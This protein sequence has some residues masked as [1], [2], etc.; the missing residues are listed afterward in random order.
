MSEKY[1]LY[2]LSNKGSGVIE[3]VLC[4]P[5]ICLFLYGFIY[6]NSYFDKEQRMTVLSRSQGFSHS[7]EQSD[8]IYKNDFDFKQNNNIREDQF[9]DDTIKFDSK[10]HSLKITDTW[11]EYIPSIGQGIGLGVLGVKYVQTQDKTMDVTKMSSVRVGEEYGSAEQTAYKYLGLEDLKPGNLNFE[12]YS[13][14]D[15]GF[16]ND[17][18]YT[19][20]TPLYWIIGARSQWGTSYIDD[21]LMK[22]RPYTACNGVNTLWEVIDGIAAAK[23]SAEVTTFGAVAVVE[24][25]VSYL[26]DEVVDMVLDSAIGKITDYLERKVYEMLSDMEED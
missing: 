3:F 18:Y 11:K 16:L 20:L 22:Y 1:S 26:A 12:V 19:N 15:T 17:K 4:A 13:L 8:K 2:F 25:V 6:I 24:T 23:A 10:R 9:F 7:Q 5:I 14:L 21:C